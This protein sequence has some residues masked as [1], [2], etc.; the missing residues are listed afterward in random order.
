MNI[1]FVGANNSGKTF[2]CKLLQ[3]SLPGCRIHSS[4]GGK[5]M[6]KNKINYGD[7]N[8]LTNLIAN[9]N[10]YFDMTLALCAQAE[11]NQG[12]FNLFDRTYYD[13]LGYTGYASR[14]QHPGSKEL[15]E[16]LNS[17][18]EYAQ[19]TK[20]YDLVI[21]LH[22][23]SDIAVRSEQDLQ[24]KGSTGTAVF[25]DTFYSVNT[26]SLCAATGTAFAEVPRDLPLS[27]RKAHV[28]D[29]IWSHYK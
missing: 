9:Q 4:T 21:L 10:D 7:I 27:E 19:K 17:Q 15:E 22:P 14:K 16:L 3:S 13:V 20:K 6:H 11:E 2:L 12:G 18:V 23:H 8:P 29:I 28:L 5:V 24:S 1:G 26:Q 25:T